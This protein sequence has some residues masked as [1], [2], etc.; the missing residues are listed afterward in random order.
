MTRFRINLQALFLVACVLKIAAVVISLALNEWVFSGVVAPLA[1]MAAYVFIG[2]NRV[3]R[4]VSDE[5]FADS[6]YYLGFI[7]TIASIVASLFQ[8]EQIGENLSAIAGRFGAAMVSTVV[9]IGVR[10]YLI[11]FR[12]DAGDALRN[13]EE[14]VLQASDRFRDAMEVAVQ[15]M[16]DFR[17]DIDLASRQTVEGVAM[18]IDALVRKY[19]EQMDAFFKG[20]SESTTATTRSSLEELH[21]ARVRLVQLLDE[22]SQSTQRSVAS[23]EARVLEFARVVGERM[24]KTQF[25]DDY[26]ARHLDGPVQQL[27]AASTA[28][29]AQVQ[30]SAAEVGRTTGVL[31]GALT[32]LQNKAA[33]F[34]GAMG[35]VLG[36]V[37]T[38]QAIL[39]ASE[40]QVGHL[41]KLT[42]TLKSFENVL[43]VVLERATRS[44]DQVD[45]VT[46]KVEALLADV[47]TQAQLTRT[48]I[49][50]SRTGLAIQSRVSLRLE[51][52]LT[53]NA[54]REETSAKGALQAQGDLQQVVATLGKLIV[55]LEEST[56]ATQIVVAQA[57]SRQADASPVPHTTQPPAPLALEPMDAHHTHRERSGDRSAALTLTSGGIE[58]LVEQLGAASNADG[59]TTIVVDR[60]SHAENS[61]IP[62]KAGEPH[63][64]P[65]PGQG[66]A[67]GATKG[68][69]QGPVQ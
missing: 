57:R 13:A 7:F 51:E 36:L 30:S 44:G 65:V 69:A 5:R 47:A 28:V 45:T 62:A 39:T 49:E 14:G 17:S 59:G 42:E 56:R 41:G 63:A 55:A 3:D 53:A 32:R 26:F 31:G 34:D 52:S 22:Q 50:Q 11:G 43:S 33:A 15:Q 29:A 21:A 27:R 67:P 46:N 24:E 9:G 12:R 10:V 68:T 61:A 40:G 54:R 20:L 2:H 1:V 37:E 48:A 23:I 58:H 19:G 66:S 38:Q 18:Q 64:I 35:Q 4:A 25:P 8:L 60:S 16:Q 6:C